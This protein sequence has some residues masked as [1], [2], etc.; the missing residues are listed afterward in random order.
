MAHGNCMT[1]GNYKRQLKKAA[2]ELG[3][4]MDV[5]KSIEKATTRSE[6]SKIMLKARHASMEEDKW[7]VLDN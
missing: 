1:F 4:D 7:A 2:I 3:Y 5:I 6:L